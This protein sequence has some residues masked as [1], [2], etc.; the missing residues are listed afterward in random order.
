MAASSEMA[1]GIDLGTT[2]SCVGVWKNNSVDIIANDM[3]ERTTPSYVS[4]NETERLV[5]QAAKNQCARNPTNTVFDAKR[6]IGRKFTDPVVKADMQL[7]PFKV[8]EGSQGR[9]V[10]EVSFKGEKRQFFPEEISSMVLAK[11]KQ[12]AESYI[13]QDVTGA[14]ITVPAY[15][16]DSQRQATKDAGRIANLD[17][18]RIINEPTAAAIAYGLDKAHQEEQN[19]LIFD[20]GG[21]T[22]DV[23]LLTIDDGVFEVMATAGDTHLGGEDF[24][25]KLVTHCVDD[26]CKKNGS[27][28]KSLKA[29]PRSMRRLRT[30]CESVKRTLSSA[31]RG[32]IEVDSLFEGI[33]YHSTI[34]RAKFENLCAQE[35][36]A[37][38]EPVKKVLT[39]AKVVK[40]EVNEVVLVGGSTRIPKIQKLLKTYF[41]EKELNRSINP[42]EAVAWGAAVQAAV[43]TNKMDA[44]QAPVLVDVAPLSLGIETAGGVMT[45][46]IERN[47]AIPCRAQNVFT[48]Y[49]DNQPG[50]L[51]QVF[52]GERQFTR[53]NNLLGKFD[54]QGIPAAPRGVPQIEVCFDLDANSIL[55]VSAEDKNN[56]STKKSI[57]IEQQKGRLSKDEIDR[58]VKEAEKFKVEDDAKRARVDAKNQLETVLYQSQN[59]LGEKMPELNDYLNE[60]IEWVSNNPDETTEVY[61]EKMKEIQ[62]FIQQKVQ[63]AGG[64]PQGPG[65]EE[66]APPAD[67]ADMPDIDEI[68]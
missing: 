48:T 1:V 36:Q 47:K 23:S 50:V 42:D 27:N 13:G 52:E 15:F 9:P 34:T 41:K 21:G 16:N 6:L 37:C 62:A 44:D 17:V 60:Q 65:G 8:T 3:G 14:V 40:S 2:Y 26:F 39:D 7:W 53:D 28:K 38:L 59:Q 61:Q 46:L 30:Q 63:E 57:R 29:N 35:F 24:D 58:I 54:L 45:K 12:T 4:F 51:I 49:S 55:S 31:M 67:N 19:V 66:G 22:F 20:L 5:G 43:L 64:M 10:I 56:A 32:T 18:K 68:D 11:M 25:N 33:D